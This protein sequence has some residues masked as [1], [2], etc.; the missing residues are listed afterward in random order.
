M[1]R[2]W[3]NF[4]CRPKIDQT[5]CLWNLVRILLLFSEFW[6]LKPKFWPKHTIFGPKKKIFRWW[7]ILVFFGMKKYP[8]SQN[9]RAC[10]G[11]A[12][13]ET[14]APCRSPTILDF[15]RFNGG[16][17]CGTCTLVQL[18]FYL[19]HPDQ[20]RYTLVQLCEIYSQK[21]DRCFCSATLVLISSS[22]NLRM[23]NLLFSGDILFK[24]G[25]FFH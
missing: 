16:L 14:L 20:W 22:N 25:L 13:V 9:F 17:K 12:A 23:I 18:N 10:S 4:N 19:R 8:C 5:F 11:K 3:W 7:P 21:P 2:F 24:H 15:L 1:I 6:A